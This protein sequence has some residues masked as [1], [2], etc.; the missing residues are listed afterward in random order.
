MKRAIAFA[1]IVLGCAVL[2]GVF[3]PVLTTA[4]IGS[5]LPGASDMWDGELFFPVTCL[6]LVVGPI[7]AGIAAYWIA[8]SVMPRVAVPPTVDEARIM[9]EARVA[10]ILATTL[11]WV[12]IVQGSIYSVFSLFRR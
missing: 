12:L 5:L 3:A 1:G 6:L 8:R 11:S 10:G 4:T 7:A 2:I 9:R